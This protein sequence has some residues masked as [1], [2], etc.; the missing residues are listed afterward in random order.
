MGRFQFLAMALASI[1]NFFMPVS[2]AIDPNCDY[3]Q[4]M[5]LGQTYYIYNSEYPTSY[6]T[7][8]S[9]RWKANSE[10][11]T[12]IVI[13]CE[14]IAIPSS[15]NCNADRLSISLSGNDA[16]TDS[17]NYCGTG[18][19]SLVTE[20][21][22]IAIGLFAASNSAGGRFV[23]TL[24][25]IQDSSSSTTE[26]PNV[27][28]CGWRHETRIVGGQET[29]INEYPEMAGLVDASLGELY[30]GSSIISTRY[31]LSAAHCVLNRNANNIGVLVGDHNISAG[32]DTTTAA[33]YRVTAYEM[34]PDYN[35]TTQANDIAILRTD[36]P[37]VFS[38]YVGPVCLPFRFTSF[39]FYG[40]T[41]T[42]LGWGQ[43]EFSGPTSDV[44]LEVN[45]TIV[46]NTECAPQHT[47]PITGKQ[48][49]TYSSGKDSCQSDS[50]GPL[51]WLDTSTRRLHL[52]GIISYGLACGSQVPGVNT[53]VT[54]YLSWIVSRASDSTYCIK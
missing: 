36:R 7:S 53:R 15:S 51:L 9:C 21:N 2:M 27:C 52:V 34:H 19:L 49:C 12:K 42:A 10:I 46:S 35:T 26:T 50:G 22:A 1:L 29:G 47:N 23:C 45:L 18:T 28:D 32:G 30:C 20:G 48:M 31:V 24:T 4:N 39:D 33:L 11:G 40:Q 44:L 14:D 17:H 25:A 5:I 8:T 43:T 41:V 38:I 54:S 16:F 37:I 3:Y 13:T 6:P